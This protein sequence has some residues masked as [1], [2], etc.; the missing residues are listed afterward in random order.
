MLLIIGVLAFV[1]YY[2]SDKLALAAAG[3][4]V[5]TRDEAPELHDIVERLCAM[6][7][8]PKPKIAVMDTPVPNAFATGRSPKHAAVCVTTGLWQRLDQKELEGVLAHE[9]SHIANRDV[10]IM[11]IASFFAMLAALLTRIGLYSGMFGGFGGQPRQPERPARLA[12]RALRLDG[13][14]RDQLRPDPDALALPRVRSRPRLGADHGRTRVPD[15]RA[16]EDLV[17]DDADPA[18]GSAPGRGH[19][20]VL[21]HPGAHEGTHGASSSWITRRSRSA[22]PRSPR[23]RARWVARSPEL[24]LRDVLFG[25]KQL[26]GPRD[27]RLFA[28]A[29]AAVTLETELGLKTAG[30][31]AV[32]FKPLSSG[33]FTRVDND[34]ESLIK[35]AGRSAGSRGRAEDRHLRLRVA[36]RPRPRPRGPDHLGARGGPGADRPGLRRAAARRAVPVQGRPAPGLLD[37]RL[38]ARRVLAVHPDRRGPGA[39]QRDR[40]R[41]EGEARAGASG[42][43]GSDALARAVRRADLSPG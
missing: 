40:A 1:Q 30:V 28:L 6:A 22:S 5:V 34:I 17:A 19:E 27:D 23:S 4:K 16:A 35:A 32:T 29:T 20:R 37:L 11:T 2:T 39:R 18:A 9:L 3:A 7:D 14:L 36:D 13:R 26:S 25:R 12:D 31:G 42:R 21:H 10:L 15:E 33:D 38:Q 43:A 41:A 24:G 8:L